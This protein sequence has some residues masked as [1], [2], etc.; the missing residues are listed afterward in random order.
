[1]RKRLRPSSGRSR[2]RLMGVNFDSTV[3]T[4]KATMRLRVIRDDNPI[5]AFSADF[6]KPDR[7]QQAWIGSD[8]SVQWRDVEVIKESEHAKSN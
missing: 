3:V 7:L 5:A 6:R 1:M 2:R 4:H 8:G